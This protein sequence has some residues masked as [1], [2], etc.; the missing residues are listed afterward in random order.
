MLDLL[1]QITGFGPHLR[2]FFCQSALQKRYAL[3]YCSA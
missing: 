2:P 3:G 1:V